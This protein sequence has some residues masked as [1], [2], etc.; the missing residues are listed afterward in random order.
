[1]AFLELSDGS[2]LENLT[3]SDGGLFYS[4]SE[5]SFDEMN[6][7]LSPVKIYYDDGTSI[8]LERAE[9]GT[10][11]VIGSEDNGTKT[12]KYVFSI[13]SISNEQL[14]ITEGLSIIAEWL[15][16]DEQAIQ[17]PYVFD[18]WDPNGVEYEKDISRVQYDGKLWKCVT[19]HTSQPSWT[20][21]DAPSL[22]VRIDDPSEEWP[23]WRQPTG[24]TDAYSKGDKVSHNGKHWISNIDGENT[25]TWEP[26]VYGWDEQPIDE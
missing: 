3:V 17:V 10:A 9:L 11:I 14:S 7:K 2:K 23:E 18:D 19:S 6:T 16:T 4:N 1:M 25:N 12:E 8:M 22:W 24:S 5:I 21:K 13:I 15:L 20:P 26:G